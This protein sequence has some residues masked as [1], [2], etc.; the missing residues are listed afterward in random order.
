MEPAGDLSRL[1]SLLRQR[2]EALGMTRARLASVMGISQSYIAVVED[3]RPRA[4]G[5]KRPSRPTPETLLL[6]THALNMPETDAGRAF[7]LA[8]Y[9][10]DDYWDAVFRHDEVRLDD[11]RGADD[12][13]LSQSLSS[14]ADR[15]LEEWLNLP[16]RA[17]RAPLE[18]T[19]WPARPSQP[20]ELLTV[21]EP[22]GEHPEPG[23]GVDELVEQLRRVLRFA[24]AQKAHGEI[25]IFIRHVLDLL[26][27]RLRED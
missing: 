5:R 3:A 20:Q 15:P 14:M 7:D 23:P 17:A 10:G 1:G 13:A 6:W 12:R 18:R 22:V 9:S 8:G 2:R 19:F 16:G 27:F 26:E 21:A 25:A 4:T 11:T 24:R